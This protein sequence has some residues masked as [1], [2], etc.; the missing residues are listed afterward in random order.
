VFGSRSNLNE[1]G[2][3]I[4]LYFEIDGEHL[5]IQNLASQLRVAIVNKIGE[6]K[7]DIFIKLRHGSHSTS[8]SAN[9]YEMIKN[10]IVTIWSAN[11]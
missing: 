11:D 9:F 6:Q 3:D 8:A 5:D 1:K 7:I 4:D 10:Q 2:G